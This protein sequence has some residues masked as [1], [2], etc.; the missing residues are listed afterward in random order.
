[1]EVILL[2]LS[3]IPVILLMI[4]IYRKDKYEKEPV[5]ML[6]KAFLGGIVS[7]IIVFPI[8]Y[9]FNS[10][11]YTES[12]FYLAFVEAGIPEETAKFLMLYLIIWK[13]KNFNEYMDGIVYAA[14]VGLGFACVENI[15]Y[16]FSAAGE[17][18]GTG[19]STSIT[20]AL[21]SVPAHFLFGIIM[22]YFF[23]LAKFNNGH[24]VKY[25]LT[26]LLLAILAHGL[27]DWL[28]M[29]MG[30]LGNGISA[31]LLI[32]FI[33]LDIYL[34]KSGIRLIRRHQEQSQ[35]KDTEREFEA[36]Y[37]DRDSGNIYA[38]YNNDLN[39]IDWNAGFKN[40]K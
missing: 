36:E 22:G 28:L 32:G 8:V 2:A 34:W 26:G 30:A 11:Y 3:I 38:D 33:I 25:L 17:S 21:L 23:S 10:I 9:L 5:K 29:T 1:M 12:T 35:F 20:R 37:T 18:F 24:K 7:V 40:Q 31:L 14:F 13:N 27:F 19:V 6:V 39:S 4:F 16:V 15:M